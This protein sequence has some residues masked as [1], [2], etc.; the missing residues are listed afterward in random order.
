MK[1]CV[2]GFCHEVPPGRDLLFR[3]DTKLRT[4]PRFNLSGKK[5]AFSSPG[6]NPKNEGGVYPELGAA[7]KRNLV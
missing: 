2:N 7:I 6:N 3:F 4:V 5:T 1:F